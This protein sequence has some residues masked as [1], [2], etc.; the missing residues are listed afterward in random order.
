MFLTGPVSLEY[1]I[2]PSPGLSCPSNCPDQTQK[3]MCFSLHW[4]DPAKA[5]LLY[6]S[7]LLVVSWLLFWP[8]IYPLS[9]KTE[10]KQ[11]PMKMQSGRT[12]KRSLGIMTSVHYGS[13]VRTLKSSW[14]QRFLPVFTLGPKAW[15]DL[16]GDRC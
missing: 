13:L 12:L 10:K 8:A 3:P 9:P 5:K 2:T 14:A 15:E 7:I 11:N 4:P 6:H 16:V 1:S